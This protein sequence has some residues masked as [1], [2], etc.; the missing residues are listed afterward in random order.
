M[1]P[2]A[3]AC[4]GLW[5]CRGE[6]QSEAEARAVR[7][8]AEWL[9]AIQGVNGS[10]GVAP[11]LPTPGWTTAYAILLWNAL[12]LHAPARRR[13][14]A[15]L[16]EQKGQAVAVDAVDLGTIVGHDPTLVGW[17]WVEGTHSWIEPTAMAM[18]ALD[19]EGYG[20]HPR[21][22]EG[23]RVV[24]N[25]ALAQGGWNCGNTS[26]F[27]R[28]LRPHPGPTGLALLAL[29]VCARGDRPRSVDRAIA[30]LRRTLPEVRAPISLGWGLLGLRAW[31]AC[32]AEAADWLGESYSL[33]AGRRDV[34]TGLSLLLLAHGDAPFDPGEPRS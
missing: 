29:A 20:E 25:R 19:R 12:E 24:L 32:P 17:P 31:N 7:R 21:V 33:H 28:Q 8:G 23:M 13:A 30:Y 3:M 10:L 18:L 26:V 6:S 22:A 34:I 9:L 27:G 14:A 16:L 11:A 1:E 15:W 5:S 2:T 4:L